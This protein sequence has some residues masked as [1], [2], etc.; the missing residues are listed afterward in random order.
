MKRSILISIIIL[1]VLQLVTAQTGFVK[2]KLEDSKH[3]PISYA[4]I[5]L[6]NEAGE[7]VTGTISDEKGNFILEELIFG[8]LSIDIQFVGYK[9]FNKSIVLEKGNRKVDLGNIILQE[10]AA[11]LDEVT[12]TAQKSQFTY[13]LDKKVFNVGKD[14]IS[15]GGSAI[16]V[17]N[18]VPSVSVDPG[19]TVSLRGNSGVQILING[20]RSGLTMNNALDA[21]PVNTIERVEVI[22]NPSASFDASGSA[23]IINIVLKKELGEGF[24][25]QVTVQGGMPANHVIMPGLNYKGKKINLFSSLRWRY[26]DYNG[27][28][29]AIQRV[30]DED[31]L[32]TNLNQFEDEDRHDDGRSGYFG[33]DYY[34]NNKNTITA[35]Y[36]RAETRDS[37]TTQIN[38][39]FENNDGSKTAIERRGGSVE[40]R[41]YNQ[42]EFNYIRTFDQKGKKWTVDF[43]NDFWNSNKDWNINTSGDLSGKNT[44]EKLRTN[45]IAGSKDYMLKT[46]FKQPLSE[47]SKIEFGVKGESRIV[48]NDYLAEDFTGD[49]WN[50]FDGIDNDI[51]YTEQIGAA[52]LQY[53]SSFKKVEYMIGLRS[54][55]TLIDIADEEQ[56]F[57]ENKDYLNLFP[58]AH[59]SYKLNDKNTFQGSYSRRIN[60]PSLW[61]L[62]PFFEITD[63]NWQE[64]GN[65]NLNPAFADALEVSFLGVRDKITINPSIYYRNTKADFEDYIEQNEKG[66]FITKPINIDRAQ[67][68]GLEVSVRYQPAKFMSLNTEF[69]YF[70][71]NQTGEYNGL[72]LDAR[73][74]TWSMRMNG[75][76]NLPKK[77]RMQAMFDYRGAVQT[78]QTKRLANYT[79]SFGLDKNFLNDQLN[80]SFYAFNILDSRITQTVSTG[81]NFY[82][83]HSSRR[84]GERFTLGL[85]Y[86]FNQSTR[87]RMRRARRGNR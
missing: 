76:F 7:L 24:N 37:D 13:Q 8:A 74:D 80:V 4:T 61:S 39:G 31:G 60:R 26:S 6:N 57:N 63:F 79:L 21:I 34:L 46:D 3:N 58:S 42:L 55:Y 35:A 10:D 44:V 64:T 51:Q 27:E 49:V 65:P 22:T 62:Y 23:G 12:V 84:Y 52:Y 41:N 73:G 16:D 78:A 71:F 69:N 15:K 11:Q 30:T 29:K 25:G 75:N 87:E 82:T 48:K 28:Y 33:A 67:E 18:Q 68:A 56:V 50:T 47:K 66:I 9:N 86:R 83:E 45:N 40:N 5:S 85:T 77:I 2:G 1:F 43:Q 72:N 53:E 81:E 36:F 54:E 32:T 19:G 14:V 59:L 20:K 70:Y 38:Y 17:L